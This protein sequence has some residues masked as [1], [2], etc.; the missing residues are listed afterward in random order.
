MRVRLELDL[1]Q[2]S[3]DGNIE[4]PSNT[5]AHALL[6]PEIQYQGLLQAMLPCD[7]CL[8]NLYTSFSLRVFI[9]C[10]RQRQN[11]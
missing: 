4:S 5:V 11:I 8:E 2:L 10:V 3:I 6:L 1:V 7:M 9:H